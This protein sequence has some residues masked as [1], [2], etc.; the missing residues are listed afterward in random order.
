M[1]FGKTI[2]NIKRIKEVKKSCIE[3]SKK[4]EEDF[5]Q[6]AAETQ[7]KMENFDGSDVSVQTLFV[8]LLHLANEN[9]KS[10]NIHIIFA[11]EISC[12]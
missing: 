2:L 12:L 4:K 9:G 5:S 6:I 11:R 7:E 8:C 10:N 3:M 1:R